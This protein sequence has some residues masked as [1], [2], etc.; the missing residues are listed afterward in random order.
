MFLLDTNHCSYA[1]L[2]NTQILDRLANLGNVSIST[3]TI[4]QGELIDMAARSQQRQANLTLIQRFLLGLNIYSIDPTTAEIYGNLKAAVFDHYAPKDK[5]QRRK[6]KIN[7]LGIGENDLW[8]AAVAL[9][10]QL[11]L[12]TTDRD[13]LR[14]QSVQQFDLESWV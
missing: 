9:Q 7:Q 1:I 4:V 14:I 2:G 5:A 10:H 8:I 3:C 6:T 12:L 11:T 13:F